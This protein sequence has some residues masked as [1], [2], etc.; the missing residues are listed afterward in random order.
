MIKLT[1]AS[2]NGSPLNLT[3]VLKEENQINFSG[4]WGSISVTTVPVADISLLVIDF[5]S[6]EV[7]PLTIEINMTSLM[8][9]FTLSGQYYLQVE[10]QICCTE[11]SHHSLTTAHHGKLLL[12]LKGKLKVFMVCFREQS[13]KRIMKDDLYMDQFTRIQSVR[14]ITTQMNHVIASIMHNMGKG[15]RHHIYAEA[16]ALELLSLELEQLETFA[17][18]QK[19]TL[20]KERDQERI[21]QA[22]IIIEE[23]LLNPC[24]LIELA[25]KVGLNDFKLKKGFREILGTTVFGYLYDLRM[26]KAMTLLKEGKLIR[27]VAYEVGY[28]NAHH[29]TVAF[30]KKFGYLPSKVSQFL[31]L[32]FFCI[33]VY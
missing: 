19:N 28:K 7:L 10:N 12:T 4:K 22:K 24:S 32:C 16:K 20:W 26:Y 17:L 3:N 23:N 25:H 11:S 31:G 15:G 6:D 27:D 13:L 30:K 9:N 5:D 14:P 33:S 29:F 1:S 21:H 2:V 18:Q 8:L